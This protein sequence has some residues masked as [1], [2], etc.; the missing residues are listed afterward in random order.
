MVRQQVEH[1]ELLRIGHGAAER[2]VEARREKAGGNLLARKRFL[3]RGEIDPFRRIGRQLERLQPQCLQR[4]Q[5]AEICRRLDRNRVARA[6]DGAER[7][8]QRLGAADGNYEVVRRQRPAPA[9]RPPRD[10]A[11]K[12]HVALR[13]GID[14]V[15]AAMCPR[16][17][18][19]MPV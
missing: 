5:Q 7:Q 15:V 4:M 13:A 11:P 8:D 6:R 12:L 14:V 19:Q 1:R 17:T 10:L 16:S 9:H 3:Q 2:I 18:R